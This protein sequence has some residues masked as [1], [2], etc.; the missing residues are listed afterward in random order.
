MT[1]TSR[2][3]SE[4]APFANPLTDAASSKDLKI[5]TNK[6]IFG[7]ATPEE[8]GLNADYMIMTVLQ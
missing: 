1:V 3:E 6:F 4:A 8:T 7:Q 2:R 5:R